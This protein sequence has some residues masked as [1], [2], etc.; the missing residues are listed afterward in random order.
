VF[1]N[2][3][4]PEFLENDD[5]VLVLSTTFSTATIKWTPAITL[6]IAAVTSYIIQVYDDTGLNGVYSTDDGDTLNFT[7]SELEPTTKYYIN[8]KAIN[9]V[10][11]SVPTRNISIITQRFSKQHLYSYHR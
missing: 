10:G 4:V 7:I 1:F 8:V 5:T 11:Q 3:D 6:P 9:T 2:A